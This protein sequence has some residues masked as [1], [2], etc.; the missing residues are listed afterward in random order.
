[1]LMAVK[2]PSFVFPLNARMV[3]AVE[4][5]KSA[6]LA[7]GQ[8]HFAD[9]T[10]FRVSK[11]LGSHTCYINVGNFSFSS[12][13]K[14]SAWSVNSS[15]NDGTF[16]TPPTNNNDGGTRLFQAFQA[17]RG[18]LSARI[19]EIKKNLPMKFFFFLVGF[20]CATAFATVIG[21]TGDWDILSAALAVV[22]V[23]G[24]GALMY[25][26]SLRLLSRVKNLITMFNYWKAGLSLGLFLD[27][28]KY[29]ME[30]IIGLTNNPF[31]FDIDYFTS[32]F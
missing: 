5:Y 20:Y 22:V 16:G 7:S 15:I 1:M 8:T 31:N 26:A 11:G 19:N 6:S 21:Q 13:T 4:D 23:E 18:R 24:I 9:R 25:G 2:I 27:S 12:S 30:N 28:F 14:R 29:E 10:V 32:F 17:L 3:A